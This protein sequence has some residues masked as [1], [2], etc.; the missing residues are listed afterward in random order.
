MGRALPGASLNGLWAEQLAG[1]ADPRLRRLMNRAPQPVRSPRAVA[2]RLR[3]PRTARPFGLDSVA[4]A[5]AALVH[6]TTG[7]Q[8]LLLAV[9]DRRLAALAVAV[10]AGM[11][12][13]ALPGAL[14]GEAAR[15]A[16]WGSLGI[17]ELERARL[18]RQPPGWAPCAAAVVT[19]QGCEVLG[20]P[21]RAADLAVVADRAEDVSRLGLLVNAEVLDGSAARLAVLLESLLDWFVTVREEEAAQSTPVG[22]LPLGPVQSPGPALP[23]PADVAFDD[24]PV[25]RRVLARASERPR[26]PAVAY[27]GGVLSY[28][29]LAGASARLANR[30][31]RHG[32]EPGRTVDVLLDRGPEHLIAQ[33]AVL[34]TGAA[35]RLRSPGRAA[36][37]PGGPAPA[38]VV[39]LSGVVRDGA[40]PQ[41]LLDDP[42]DGWRQLPDRHRDAEPPGPYAHL[43]VTAEDGDALRT[44]ALTHRR[45]AVGASVMAAEA[46]LGPVTRAGWLGPPNSGLVQLDCLPV[47]A[48]GGLVL[49]PPDSLRGPRRLQQWLLDASATH[50]LLTTAVAEDLWSL[51]WPA[52]TGLRTMAVTGDRMSRWPDPGLP[53]TVLNLYG[54]ARAHLV[55][56]CDVSRL[57]DRLDP[58]ERAVAG[59]PIGRPVPG[60]A[61]LHI[62][63]L[64]G[65]EVP[66]GVLGSLRVVPAPEGT[67]G[68]AAYDSGDPARRW[69]DG[70]IEVLPRRTP[71]PAGLPAM[72][73]APAER[74]ALLWSQCLDGA[75][76]DGGTHFFDE[77]GDSLAGLR[78]CRR[79]TEAFGV[80]FGLGDLTAAPTPVSAAARLAARA[81]PAAVDAAPPGGRTGAGHPDP[82]VDTA[83]RA[84]VPAA[85]LRTVR[86]LSPEDVR[87]LA[88]LAATADVGL[89]AVLGTALADLLAEAFPQAAPLGWFREPD[90][91][92]PVLV[93]PPAHARAFADRAR[94]T[95]H[96]PADAGRVRPRARLTVLPSDGPHDDSRGA[97]VPEG[98]LDLV[99]VLGGDRLSLKWS[100]ADAESR[101]LV[102]AYGHRLRRLAR[103]N[104]A[105]WHTGAR[106]ADGLSDG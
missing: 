103:E 12:A 4:A 98:G 77:G 41:V 16:G 29:E 86:P 49:V 51:P 3:L 14:R 22:A 80:P 65:T 73:M 20:D 91:P 84:D 92:G 28:G 37:G 18:P 97:M 39:T 56:L 36:A 38:A 43:A 26:A 21:L 99:V 32:A 79:I 105:W 19:Q 27:A 42:A 87:A 95:Q 11:P 52:G 17:G 71:G 6:R 8:E 59:P 70:Q 44:V 89:P 78:L 30:L 5:V 45:A 62:V 81:D 104:G 76:S 58:R 57:A 61:R 88:R 55:A 60:G 93:T 66:P 67:A 90:G 9:A 7:A 106:E 23:P 64:H 40:A 46:G 34:R 33:L 68:P 35:V 74:L 15:T 63:D 85:A 69:S 53:F 50:T 13:S 82:A 24:S 94:W 102:A 83:D 25:H 31:R 75:D 54:S 47:L 1:P 72:E 10:D 2:R 96:A 100:L 101:P 48:A